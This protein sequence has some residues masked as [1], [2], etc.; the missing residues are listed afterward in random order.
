MLTLLCCPFHPRVI[1]GKKR[2]KEKKKDYSAKSASGGSQINMHTPSTQRS[3]RG[4]TVCPGIARGPIRQTKNMELTR[5]SSGNARPLSHWGGVSVCE[6]P[7][8]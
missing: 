1:K 7:P 5:V 4:L 3:R 8:P 2:K 6:L